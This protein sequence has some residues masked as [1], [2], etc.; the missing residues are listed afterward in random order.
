MNA[1]ILITGASGSTGAATLAALVAQPDPTTSITTMSR[2]AATT[3][4][5]NVRHAIADFS[6][7]S[8]ISAALDGITA[9]YLVTPSTE[10]AEQQQ[11]EFIDVAKEAGVH[12]IVLLSQYACAIESPVRFLRYH[13]AVEEHLRRSGIGATFLR[14]NLFMQ[15]LLM[16][17]DS[18]RSQ[19]ALFA[20]IGDARVSAVDVRDIGEVAAVALMATRP[21][22][23]LNI[24]GPEALTHED[25]TDALGEALGSPVSFHEVT[26][27]DFAAALDGVLPPWQLAGLL[28]DYEHYARGEAAEVSDNVSK[29]LGRAPRNIRDFAA[30]AA[31]GLL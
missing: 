16:F 7:R 8:S 23:T 6:D 4:I 3:N 2:G 9:A 20:P 29:L 30:D 21:L 17:G 31:P 1:S 15:G 19:H 26:P 10:R 11:I 18:I 14:P 13:A 25:M 24:T 22:G 27:D 28:E 12:H 5:P